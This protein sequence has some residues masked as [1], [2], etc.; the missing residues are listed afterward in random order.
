MRSSPYT[1]LRGTRP[2]FPRRTLQATLVL[3]VTA[4]LATAAPAAGQ[5]MAASADSATSA[6]RSAPTT[7]DAASGLAAKP[8][9]GWSSW[10]IGRAHV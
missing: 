4:A 6:V 3:A 1:A 8:Y 10:K 2:G 5:A 7:A 9:M